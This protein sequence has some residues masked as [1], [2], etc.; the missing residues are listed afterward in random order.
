[1]DIALIGFT[2]N[3]FYLLSVSDKNAWYML[4]F[5]TI[6]IMHGINNYLTI[7]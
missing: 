4:W 6:V 5:V 3:I 1:M 7:I 2:L